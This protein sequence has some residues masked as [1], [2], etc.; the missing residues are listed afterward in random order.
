M[1]QSIACFLLLVLVLPACRQTPETKTYPGPDEQYGKLF[2]EVQLKAIFPDSKTFP[3]CEP[4]RP[5]SEILA[6]YEG[7][8]DKPGFNLKTFVS[9]NFSLPETPASG[10]KSDPSQSA[11]EHIN[12]LWPV[13]TRPADPS[14]QVGSRLALPKPYVVP[15]GRFGEMYYWDSYFTLLGLQAAGQD[16]AVR[17]MVDNFAHLL[18]TY[19]HIPNGTRSYYLSRSQPP[20]FALMVQL[21][22]EQDSTALT[23]YLPQLQREYYYWMG[24]DSDE[25]AKATNDSLA[26]LTAYRRTVRLPGVPSSAV[27]TPEGV[28]VNRYCDDL[29]TPRPEAYKEDVAVAK[30]SGRPVGEVYRHLRSG[31]ESGWDFSS[32]WL[33]DGRKLE[34]IHT[35]DIVPVD[36]NCLLY[37]LEKTMADAYRQTGDERWTNSFTRL[38]EK[39]RQAI[40]ASCWNPEKGFFFD[41]DWKTKTQTDALTLAGVFPLFVGMATPEEAQA[42]ASMLKER[43]LKPGG[44]NTTLLNTGQQWDA[45]NGWA[46]LQWVAIEGLRRYN[47]N[48]LAEQV[49]T[50]WVTAN[51]RVY[52]ATGKMVEKYNVDDQSLKAGGGE[53]PLQDGFGWTNGVLLRLLMEKPTGTRRME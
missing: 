22:A 48:D 51:L 5:P 46:P 38:A 10:Y 18:D 49:K 2:E 29:A 25:Q 7:E 53:Y 15:G 21:V 41:Y 20:F 9:E 44:L 12:A 42:V 32:R 52:K 13:L 4:K 34:T 24:A 45:P 50:N 1:K 11:E 14:D 3:D 16:T 39:R 23:R 43:F 35:T 33:A 19:G 27:P 31:A 26:R 8:K 17:H 6:A 28:T 30:R 47:Q 36:L 37:V 40:I